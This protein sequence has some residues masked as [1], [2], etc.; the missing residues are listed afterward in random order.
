METISIQNV[1]TKRY[2]SGPYDVDRLWMDN[3]PYLGLFLPERI[4]LCPY[5]LLNGKEAFHRDERETKA[6]AIYQ[7]ES[8]NSL[9]SSRMNHST[10]DI[11][12]SVRVRF[13]TGSVDPASDKSKQKDFWSDRKLYDIR[14]SGIIHS[15]IPKSTQTEEDVTDRNL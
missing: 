1:F 5:H 13:Q 8:R 2:T 7:I 9:S 10:K 4:A 12:C 15:G 3:Q 11:Q 14:S 6:S